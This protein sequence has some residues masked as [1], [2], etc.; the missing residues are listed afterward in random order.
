MMMLHFSDHTQHDQTLTFIYWRSVS[1]LFTCLSLVKMTKMID[2]GGDDDDNDSGG[3][4][5]NND[6]HRWR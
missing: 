4:G 6:M 5:Y 3:D 1:L 2:D